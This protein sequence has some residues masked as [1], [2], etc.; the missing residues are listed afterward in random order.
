MRAIA[1]ARR[2]IPAAIRAIEGGDG[3]VAAERCLAMMRA[4]GRNVVKCLDEK[5]LFG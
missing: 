3:D 4:H 1:V 5:G 2:D